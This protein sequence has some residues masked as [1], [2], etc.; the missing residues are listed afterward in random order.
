MICGVQPKHFGP[1]RLK[2]LKLALIPSH[3][4]TNEFKIAPK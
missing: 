4:S 1:K 2:V 3:N